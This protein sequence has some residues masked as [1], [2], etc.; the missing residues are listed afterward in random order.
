MEKIDLCE[1]IIKS[2]NIANEN[3]LELERLN[4]LFRY[5][6]KNNI[7]NLFGRALFD[8]DELE[9][10]RIKDGLVVDSI[11]G[12]RLQIAMSCD[13]DYS[14]YAMD[15]NAK[16]EFFRIFMND[17]KAI[18]ECYVD[19]HSYRYEIN[20]EE[21]KFSYVSINDQN[22]IEYSGCL[23]PLGTKK[24]GFETFEYQREVPK[25]SEPKNV[26]E[27]IK[28]TV[29]GENFVKIETGYSLKDVVHH[30]EAIFDRLKLEAKKEKSKTLKNQ[31]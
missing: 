29:K 13:G 30:A 25:T 9:V 11:F 1:A 26:M 21:D 18:N 31:G 14:I 23:Q 10:V 28:R 16:K 7:V 17:K 22:E 15:T 8:E 5:F 24:S 2:F 12:V 6:I 20:I 3:N 27:R 4:A 19:G